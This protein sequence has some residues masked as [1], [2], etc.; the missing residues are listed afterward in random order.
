MAA[1]TDA[2]CSGTRRAIGEIWPATA[3][4]L[5]APQ[6]GARPKKSGI[7]IGASF[8]DS[9]PFD[10]LARGFLFDGILILA[11]PSKL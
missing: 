8:Y 3:G 1:R 9:V 10:R 2:S 5:A 11:F 4:M 6:C 7:E